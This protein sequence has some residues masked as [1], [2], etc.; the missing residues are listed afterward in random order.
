[1]VA[2]QLAPA[3]VNYANVRT[4]RTLMYALTVVR[5]EPFFFTEHQVCECV[6]RLSSS[7]SVAKGTDP[8][9]NLGPYRCNLAY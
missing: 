5:D 8:Q 6:P 3:H 7:L 1:M 9:N 4:P 2:F